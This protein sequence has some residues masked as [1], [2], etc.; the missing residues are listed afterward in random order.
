MKLKLNLG[1]LRKLKCFAVFRTIYQELSPL[2]KGMDLL[3]TTSNL[4]PC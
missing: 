3:K 4:S 1:K 2:E